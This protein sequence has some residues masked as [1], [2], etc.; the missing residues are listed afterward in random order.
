MSLH[1]FP[2]GTL[3][4]KDK[5]N[6]LVLFKF[7][8][9]DQWK[10]NYCWASFG[11]H[12]INL[13]SPTLGLSKFNEWKSSIKEGNNSTPVPSDIKKLLAKEFGDGK[14]KGSKILDY[15]DKMC[16]E[17]NFYKIDTEKVNEKWDNDTICSDRFYYINLKNVV[18]ITFRDI[19]MELH[20]GNTDK[21]LQF[22][23]DDSLIK[24]WEKTN[25]Q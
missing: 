10:N 20:F 4:N 17:L 7:E 6:Y 5:I 16:S 9:Y 25:E 22:E 11:Q 2:D 13:D 1:K 14:I 24:E 21:I 3:V 12:R 18:G 19:R 23:K 8:A 15:Y